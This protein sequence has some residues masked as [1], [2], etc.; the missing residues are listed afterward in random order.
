MK[1]VFTREL[2][3]LYIETMK[4]SVNHIHTVPAYGRAK[5]AAAARR[6]SGHG[7]GS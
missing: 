4:T 2:Q 5:A 1:R 3:K 6:R 7:A